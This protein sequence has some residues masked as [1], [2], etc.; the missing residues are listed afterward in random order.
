[1]SIRRHTTYNLIGT[2]LPIVVSLFTIPIYIDEIGASRYG[3]LAIAWL[4]LGYFGLFDLGLGRA[5]AQRIA[6]L[7]YNNSVEKSATFWTALAI[8]SGLGLIGAAIM[9]PIALYFFGNHFSVEGALKPEILD[10]VLWLALAVPV[11]TISGVLSGTLQGIS[12]FLELNIISVIGSALTQLIPLAV[13]LLYG[14]ELTWL[15]P[16]TIFTRFS[17][18]LVLFQRCYSHILSGHPPKVSKALSCKLLSFGGWVTVSAVIGPMMVILDRFVI[19]AQL[20][21][22]FVTFYTVPFQ[23]AERTS[24]IPIALSSALFPRLAQTGL[25]SG[26]ELLANK[27][28]RS[29]VVTITPLFICGIFFIDWFLKLWVGEDFANQSSFVAQILL[30]GFWGNAIAIIPHALLQASGKPSIVAKCH[31]VEL[32]PYILMLY[33][34]LELLG[35]KGAAI[36]FS[37]RSI[38]DAAILMYFAKILRQSLK[39]LISPFF[40]IFASILLARPEHSMVFIVATGTVLAVVCLYWAF[41]NMPKQ[42]ELLLTNGLRTIK[43]SFKFKA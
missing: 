27:S 30:F 12:K 14:P 11:A 23:L 2:V 33:F 9:G 18:M 24:V 19:G 21:A 8:N 15:I 22:K 36:A 43:N 29:L 28:I 39:F 3:V 34:G 20:G 31:L 40:I 37:V 5:T 6:M 10:S 25:N 16:V 17:V 35:I 32:I 4:L 26:G 1:M 42:L 41:I 38:V 13:A 7:S